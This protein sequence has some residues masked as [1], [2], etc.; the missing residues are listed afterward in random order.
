[1]KIGD[2]VR[3]MGD[4]APMLVGLTGTIAEQQDTFGRWGVQLTRSRRSHV[5]HWLMPEAL[6]VL[7]E[8]C[9]SEEVKRG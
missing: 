3:V 4:V 7:D 2:K 1:M 5:C 8:K 9:G 6:E